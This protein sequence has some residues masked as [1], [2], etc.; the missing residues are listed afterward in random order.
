MEKVGDL[1]RA[2]DRVHVVHKIHEKS[3]AEG[4][5]ARIAC[6]VVGSIFKYINICIKQNKSKK[7]LSDFTRTF[8]SA[9]LTDR[10]KGGLDDYLYNMDDSEVEKLLD[11]IQISLNKRK[12]RK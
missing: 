3:K 6:E 9:I 1:H 5:E 7:K 12:R 4:S 8:I 11:E 10:T 2:F